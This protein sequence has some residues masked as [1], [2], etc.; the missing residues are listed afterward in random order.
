MSRGNSE[1]RHVQRVLSA[2]S[3][4]KISYQWCLQMVVRFKEEALKRKREKDVTVKDTLVS[5]IRP[6]NRHKKGTS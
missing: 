4:E 5:L 1:A 2:E 6:L 3:G